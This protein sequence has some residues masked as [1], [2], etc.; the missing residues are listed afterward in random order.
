MWI[1]VLYVNHMVGGH[2]IIRKDVSTKSAA[3]GLERIIEN[4]R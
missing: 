3:K 4:G 2:V 1:S